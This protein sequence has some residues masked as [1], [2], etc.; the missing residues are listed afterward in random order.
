MRPRR[1]LRG[2]TAS[3]LRKA[4]LAAVVLFLLAGGMLLGSLSKSESVFGLDSDAGDMQ[5]ALAMRGEESLILGRALEAQRQENAELALTRFALQQTTATAGQQA[6]DLRQTNQRLAADIDQLRAARSSPVANVVRT[7]TGTVVLSF[8][9]Y[10]SAA[11]VNAILDVLAR[12]KVKA[13]FC[14]IGNWAATN[15]SLVAR[16]T[17]EGHVLCNHTASHANLTRLSDEAMRK[18]IL[19]GPQSTLLRP[20]YGAYDV[21]VANIAGSL[22]DHLFLWSIDTRDW[23]GVSADAIVNAVRSGLRPGAI[24]LMHLHGAS[25]LDALPRVIEQVRAAGYTLGLP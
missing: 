22:G 18:E 16:M 5:S 3:W 20:P 24:V 17:S 12:Y 8:D 1:S 9:D 13:V 21:R 7:G 23:T 11:R 4:G 15:P 6:D 25:T 10:A 2:Q 19:G 14:L